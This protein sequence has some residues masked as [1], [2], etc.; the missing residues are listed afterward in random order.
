MSNPNSENVRMIVGVGQSL[1][2]QVCCDQ[3]LNSKGKMRRE[4]KRKKEKC[5]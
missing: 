4:R 3:Q 5:E 1:T 2:G